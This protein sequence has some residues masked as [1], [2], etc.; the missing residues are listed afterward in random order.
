MSVLRSILFEKWPYVDRYGTEEDSL[1]I[2]VHIANAGFDSGLIH[3]GLDE[4]N[5]HTKEYESS[6]EGNFSI[7]QT[8]E[9]IVALQKLVDQYEA[10]Q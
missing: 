1:A 8:K 7:E 10:Q 2:E 3:I 4:V 9:I 6:C 5:T